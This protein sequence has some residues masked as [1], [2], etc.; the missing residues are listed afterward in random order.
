MTDPKTT[1]SQNKQL[2]RQ[3]LAGY[4]AAAEIIEQERIKRLRQMK[5][6]ES[7]AEYAAL[8]AF[9]QAHQN[10][11]DGEG[12]ERLEKWRLEEKIAMRRLFE[13]VARGRGLL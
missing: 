13:M 4:A 6:E 1:A 12:L 11:A 7:R 5:V 10:D 2:I 8:I 3:T 9:H